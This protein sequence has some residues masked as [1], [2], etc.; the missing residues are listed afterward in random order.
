MPSNSRNPKFRN[1]NTPNTITQVQQLFAQG[2]ALHQKG[3]LAKAQALYEQVLKR[4]PRHFDSLHLLGVIA[5]QTKQPERAVE[6][7]DQAI[8]INPHVAAA[9]SNRGLALNDLEQSDAALANFDKAIA[10]QPD[11]AEAYNNR[12]NVLKGLKQ[13]E[14]AVQSYDQAIA[15]KPDYAEAYNN[16]GNA[17]KDL[18]QLA[19]AVR[20]YDQAIA[21]KPDYAEAYCNRGNALK[22]LRQF[23]AAVMS[24]DQAVD[25]KPD[26]AQAYFN[27][28][29]ALQDINQFAAAIASYDRAIV[30]NPDYVEAYA[31]RGVALQDS[32]QFEA[33]VAS[34]DRAIL[35]K[36]DCVE[37]YCNRGIALRELSRLDDAL[38]NYD[39]AIALKPD[40]AEAYGNRGNVLKDLKQFEAAV[41]NYERA[42]TIRPEYASA[43]LG[44]SLT[45]LSMGD[46][47]R[48]WEEYEWRWKSEKLHSKTDKRNFSKPLWLGVEP[49]QGKT[50][51]LYAEQGLGDTLQFCRYAKL[52]SNLG[53]R[54]VLEVQPTL[55]DLLATLDGPAQVLA[56]GSALPAFDYQ[57]PL[58]SLP[59]AFKTDLASIP[60][61]RSYIKVNPGKLAQW[62]I[63]LG[64][65]H[66]LRIG[67][68]W[69]GNAQH[70]NDR[71]RSLA[72]IDLAK[73]LSVDY[74]LISLQKEVRV[75]DEDVLRAHPGIRHFGD[76]LKDFADTAALCELMDVVISVD[77]SVA[78]LAAALGKPVWILLPFVPDWRWLLDRQDSPWYPSAKLYR[79]Q[80]IGDW[81]DVIE[82]VKADLAVLLTKE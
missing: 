54:V 14:A 71:N 50:I 76:E 78:H 22:E 26:Y 16:R 79:Q 46:F 20:S 80:K 9:Y 61:A 40:Y 17:L 41:D 42:V 29:V 12:G 2:F 32:G 39:R 53:A 47:R 21:L 56:K 64:E 3:Q 35:I 24:Y 59:L 10:I 11:H 58:F 36:P 8:A 34:Y 38:E 4:Q 45:L 60:S 31:N 6:L 43:H 25:I 49:L 52:V 77:T 44:Y 67:V 7:I 62:H 55:L 68:V 82:R 13:L 63:R 73:L 19:A 65:K 48:G 28:G 74:E 23:K 75:Q 18:R 66:K 69:S 70:K 81:G 57:C 5:C 1:S 51:L 72:L 33:A 30:I 27:R 37:A 15:L